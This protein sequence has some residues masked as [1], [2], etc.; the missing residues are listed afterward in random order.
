MYGTITTTE[1]SGLRIH[2]YTAPEHGW[3]AN[4]HI[5][6]L[7]SQLVIFDAQLT[8]AYA[9]DVTGVADSLGKP[10][11]RLYVSH[12]HPDHFA[13]AGSVSAPSY[14]LES[15]K[16]LIDASGDVRIERG[17]RCT[18]GHAIAEPVLA[19]PVDHVVEPGEE[20]IDGVRFSFTPVADAE[21]TEQ[22]TIGL[23]DAGILLAQD[24]VY[25]NV[26]LFIAEQAF[27]SWAKALDTLEARPYHTILPGHGLPTDRSVYQ[28]NRDYLRA[29]RDA[30]AATT[31]PD[32]LNLRLTAAFPDYGGTAM[33]GL[34]NFYLFPAA[35]ES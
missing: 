26:H 17:Y 11:T 9:R 16:Y 25:H 6:E 33:E 34:Q 7:P 1:A 13:G 12:A 18:P 23:P 28:R 35:R 27:A 3:R 2:T 8:P 31:G 14:A 19:R 30:L 4:S 21:T 24:V 15:V 5:I 22:L 29:A 32:D 10:V 20:I